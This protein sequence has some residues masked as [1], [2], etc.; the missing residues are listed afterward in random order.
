MQL[1]IDVIGTG[2]VVQRI[3]HVHEHLVATEYVLETSATALATTLSRRRRHLR[4][5]SVPHGAQVCTPALWSAS[6]SIRCP[7]IGRNEL[8]R[9]LATAWRA[10]RSAR[11]CILRQAFLKPSAPDS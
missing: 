5:C 2:T 9:A 7:C 11:W 3:E 6:V 4:S 1:D 8:S 10:A